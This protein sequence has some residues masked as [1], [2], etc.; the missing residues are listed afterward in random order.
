MDLV[1]KVLAQ[2]MGVDCPFCLDISYEDSEGNL[3][4]MFDLCDQHAKPQ[5]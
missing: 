4:V 1:T 3:H 2:C 5:T